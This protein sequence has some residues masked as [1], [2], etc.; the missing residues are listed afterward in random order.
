MEWLPAEP[1][2][3]PKMELTGEKEIIDCDMVLLALGFLKPEHP[4]Y[5]ANVFLAGY[6]KNGASLVVRAIAS[7]R[8]TAQA[9][10]DYLKRN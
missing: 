4:E 6:S 1:G 2:Q 10:D 5:P 8:E 3:R 9:V 7:G